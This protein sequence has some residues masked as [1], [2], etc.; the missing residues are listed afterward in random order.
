MPFTANMYMGRE[1]MA[2]LL[3]WRMLAFPGV[4]YSS[5][6]FVEELTCP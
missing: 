2:G 6:C 4:E 1:I 5:T 3:T